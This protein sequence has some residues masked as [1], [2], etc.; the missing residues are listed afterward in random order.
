MSDAAPYTD[1]QVRVRDV[2]LH[3]QEW[4]DS[5]APP[6]LMV[7][8]FGV[9][10]H[11]FDEFAAR[12]QGMYRLIAIDQRGHGDSDWAP[13]GDYSRDA[14][15]ADLEAFREA[16]SIENFVLIGHS[17]GGMNSAFYAANHP[18]RVKSLVLVDVGPEAAKEG[19]DNIMRFTRGP[20]ELDFNEFVENALRFNPRRT[21]EN[22]EERMRH[23]LKEMPSGKW[24]WKFDKRFREQDSGLRIGSQATNE[25]TW[26]VFKSIQCPVLLVRG[27]QSDVLKSDVADRCVSEMKECALV[28]VA[29]AGHSVPG[30]NPDGFTEPVLEFIERTLHTA[31]A[32]VPTGSDVAVEDGPTLDE[33]VQSHRSGGRARPGAFALLGVLAVGAVAVGAIALSRKKKPTKREAAVAAVESHRPHVD[34][35]D[36]RERAVRLAGELSYM[37]K[38]QAGRARHRLQEIEVNQARD[39]ALEI[40]HILG[41]TSRQ[42]PVALKSVATNSRQLAARQAGKKA[43]KSGGSGALGAV[44]WLMARAGKQQAEKKPEPRR[45]MLPW[46]G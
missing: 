5:S 41:R 17:M 39:N 45:K 6:V 24:T 25:E 40:A 1:N 29:G 36:A 4:G 3:Y 27:E 21:R 15:V 14:F 12:A 31:E 42:A 46:R 34:I 43:A 22:I 11:M 30:D 32:E 28:T 38:D 2:T 9:S 18:D 23:R 37:A 13:D 8:G 16:L 10:G 7:H 26:D 19:V 44:R 33:L 35:D 20:D